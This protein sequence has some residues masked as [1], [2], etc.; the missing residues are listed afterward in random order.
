MNLVAATFGAEISALYSGLQFISLILP[1]ALVN[2]P[3]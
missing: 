1:N 2:F 3:G